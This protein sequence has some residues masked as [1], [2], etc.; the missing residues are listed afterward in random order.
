ME[1]SPSHTGSKLKIMTK[2]LTV[3]VHRHLAFEDLGT[4][5]KVFDALDAQVS[6]VDIGVDAPEKEDYLTPDLLVVLGGP[7]GVADRADYPFIDAEISG[8]T[9]RLDRSLPTLGVCLGAQFMAVAAGGNVQPAGGDNGGV[10]GRMEI[11]FGQISVGDTAV[12]ASSAVAELAGVE[13]VHWH[14]DCFSIPP[15]AAG[16]VSLA[17]TPGYPNQAFCLESDGVPYG[18]ALQFH[19]E[20]DHQRVE[21]WLIGHTSDLKSQGIDIPALRADAAAKGPALT[22]ASTRMLTRWLTQVGVTA[23]D[24]F[25]AQ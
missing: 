1:T 19:P 7:I 25:P 9:A 22:E 4:W 10:A 20:F 16:K 8:L 14:G 11:G 21:Q 18:L 15:A 6:Y 3:H 24:P 2:P 12:A 13:V 5:R 23:P 17:S